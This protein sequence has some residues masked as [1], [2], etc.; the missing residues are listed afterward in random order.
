ML[1]G[2][3]KIYFCL[4]PKCHLWKAHITFLKYYRDGVWKQKFSPLL[5]YN[6]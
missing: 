2:H 6:I 1:L 4:T 3:W 5:V